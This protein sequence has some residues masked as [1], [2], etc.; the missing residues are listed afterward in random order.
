VTAKP[1]Q[2]R[3]RLVQETEGLPEPMITELLNFSQF[4]K[5]RSSHNLAPMS[6]ADYLTAQIDYLETVLG[7]QKGLVSFD[8]GDG[9]P[10]IEA[11]HSLRQTLNSP[12]Q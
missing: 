9:I 8:R 7:I 10:A 4:L 11:L 12:T 1:I 3:D 5:A 2:I 6:N